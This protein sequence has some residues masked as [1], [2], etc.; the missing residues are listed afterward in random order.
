[1]NKDSCIYVAGHAG[2]VGSAV[3]RALMRAGYRNLVLARSVDLD[4]RS[5][6]C[7][8]EFFKPRKID[9]V[10]MCAAR[11]G[12]IK[13]N[14][15]N[16]REF[17]TDNMQIEMNVLREA[18]RAR[19]QKLV[20]L[21]SSCIYP[22]F[23]PQ[24]IKEEYLLTG[25][26]EPTTE[27]YALAKIAGVRM[28]QW[29]WDE[30]NKF[31]SAMPC[32]LFGPGDCMDPQRAHVIPG[33]IARMHAAKMNGDTQFYVW[34]DGNAKREYLYS[35]DLAD[36]LLTVMDKYDDREPINTGSSFE[37]SIAETARAVAAI[38]E[39]KGELLFDDAQPV[40]TPRKVLDNSKIRA[41][42]WEPKTG[43]AAALR[44]TYEDFLNRAA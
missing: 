14:R 30:G 29:L 2:L 8:H 34:G 15:D 37:L 1:M 32:N 4:L 20:F 35:N 36:A 31:V 22:K 25:E 44:A 18:A 12:G 7:V 39:Y 38:V 40:G 21:G 10:F 23:C 33:L 3:V 16:P 11:V 5:E 26:I 28:C 17:F 9:Y 13:D 27:P 6:I 43:F 42:G 24:P 41:L 19:V